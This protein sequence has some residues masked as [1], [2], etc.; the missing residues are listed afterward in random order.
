M[1]HIFLIISVL[2]SILFN[3]NANN[4]E[5]PKVLNEEEIFTET[6]SNE[7]IENLPSI[8]VYKIIGVN[9]TCTF[10]AKYSASENYIYVYERKSGRSLWFSYTIFNNRAY[11][12]ENDGRSSFRYVAGDYYFN[13]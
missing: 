3:A 10:T 8:T 13:L 7:E 9:A 11:G 1:K 2:L 4:N 5:N 6:L 12:Q